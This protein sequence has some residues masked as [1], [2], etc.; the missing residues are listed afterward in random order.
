VERAGDYHELPSFDMELVCIR[1][2]SPSAVGNDKKKNAQQR[3]TV[4]RC[5][6]QF[7][8]GRSLHLVLER[9]LL[10]IKFKVILSFVHLFSEDGI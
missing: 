2:Q 1:E 6:Q 4:V 9:K 10:F 8:T 3:V 5:N 7:C